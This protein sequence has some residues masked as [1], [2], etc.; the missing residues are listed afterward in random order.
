MCG[1]FLIIGCID[2]QKIHWYENCQEMYETCDI[3]IEMVDSGYWEVFS[4]DFTLIDRLAAKFKDTK[5]LAS[6]FEK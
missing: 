5:F 3:V 4:K 1:I 6:D 2:A